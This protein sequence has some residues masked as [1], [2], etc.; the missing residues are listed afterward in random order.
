M[1]GTPIRA[2]MIIHQKSLIGEFASL[3]VSEVESI[4]RLYHGELWRILLENRRISAKIKI[5]SCVYGF[6]RAQFKKYKAGEKINCSAG[7]MN[8][9]KRM[10]IEQ[11]FGL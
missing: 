5:K 8:K 10:A 6:M 3:V 4:E 7:L 2:A 9:I 11:E 1:R